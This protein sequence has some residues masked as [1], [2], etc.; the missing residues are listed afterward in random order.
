MLPGFAPTAKLISELFINLIK[1]LIAPIIFFTIV[2]GIAKMGDMKKWGVWAE[3]PC[4]TS[5]LL[6]PSR[7]ALACSWPIS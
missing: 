4:C 1:M 5:K 7:S 6:P 3:K 2:L